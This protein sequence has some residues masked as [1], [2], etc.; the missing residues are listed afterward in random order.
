MTSQQT[1]RS[2]LLGLAAVSVS[3]SLPLH[4]LPIFT[5]ALSRESVDGVQKAGLMAS[6]FFFAQLVTTLILPLLRHF[7]FGKGIL[8][9]L[10]ILLAVTSS[11]SLLPFP[12]TYLVTWLGIGVFAGVVQ[13]S[14]VL[15]ASETSNPQLAFS[16]RIAFAIISSG[17]FLLLANVFSA[18]ISYNAILPALAMGMA[19]ALVLGFFNSAT[20]FAASKADGKM[21]TREPLSLSRVIML[22]AI[23][24]FSAGQMGFVSFVV[25]VAVDSGVAENQTIIAIALARILAAYPIIWVASRFQNRTTGAIFR[26]STPALLLSIALIS[27]A[28]D[29]FLFSMAIFLFEIA[30]NVTTTA[31]MA[32]CSAWDRALV[33]KWQV[34]ML[35]IGATAGPMVL[36]ATF[37][38]TGSLTVFL[39][40]AALSSLIPF[41]VFRLLPI[42][43]QFDA[44]AKTG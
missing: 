8:A 19:L 27:G 37:E 42:Q 24:V 32:Y 14:T 22:L 33:A 2:S 1:A 21:P 28:T 3:A 7:S 29:I 4:L 34:A 25:F 31:F 41:G 44:G 15:A 43:T 11:M 5:Q 36:A 9:G 39:V 30:L 20:L 13:Y 23:A 16:Y 12:S 38:L 35:F 40:F 6:T 26:Y 17:T 18:Q 10:L